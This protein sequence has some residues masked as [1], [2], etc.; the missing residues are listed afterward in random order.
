VW[1][2][3]ACRDGIC[4]AQDQVRELAQLPVRV[5]GTQLLGVLMYLQASEP[6]IAELAAHVAPG[7]FL[8][9]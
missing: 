4:L 5:S 3:V 8:A 6:V 9:R 2:S 7:G 1:S